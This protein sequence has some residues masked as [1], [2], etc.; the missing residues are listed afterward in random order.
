MTEQAALRRTELDASWSV[1]SIVLSE[2]APLSLRDKDIPA[3]VPGTVH[4]DLLSAG[5]IADPYVSQNEADLQWIGRSSW[6]YQT[7]F[8]WV[9]DAG[10]RT[11]LV[12]H[13][14][15]T[16]ASASL[17]GTGLLSASNMHRTYR[18]DVSD[19]I[20][21]GANELVVDFQA[22]VP[23]AEAQAAD[24]GS[25]PHTNHHPYNQIRKM[26]CNFGWDWGPDL[27]TVGLWRQVDIETWSTARIGSVRLQPDVDPDGNGRV[28]ADVSVEFAGGSPDALTLNGEI[29]GRAFTETMPKGATTT[30]FTV[31][32]GPVELWWPHTMGKQPL[33]GCTIDLRVDDQPLDRVERTIGFRQIH[34]EQQA[35]AEGSS[36]QLFVNR[37]PMWVR[38]A[39]WIPN[40]AFPSRVSA[41]DYRTRIDQARD[42]QIDLLRVWGGGIYESDDFYDACDELGVLVWQDFLFTCAAYPERDDFAAEVAAEA[43]DNIVRLAPHPSLALWNGNNENLWGFED[44]GWKEPLDGRPWGNG[45]YRELLPDLVAELDPGRP[46]IP[47]SPYSPGDNHPNDPSRGIIHIWD[48]WNTHDYADYRRYQARFVS[49]FGYQAPATYSTLREALSGSEMSKHAPALLSHQK[50]KDGMDKLR[51][52]LDAH[53]RDP[54]DF[55]DWHFLAQLNQARAISLGVEWFRSLKQ[56]SGS[57]VWQLND[58]WPVVSWSAIDGS[59]RKKPLWYA[60]RRAY[61]DRL[62]TVQPANKTLAVV[63]HNLSPDVWEET[64]Q[65]CRV[66]TDR[67][68]KAELTL[69]ASCEPGDVVQIDLPQDVATSERPADEFLI[70]D[71]R[72]QRSVWAYARDHSINYPEGSYDAV[73][74]GDDNCQEVT[75][76]AKTLLRDICLFPD[77]VHPDAEVDKM[78]V[79]LLPGESATF[80]VSGVDSA[81]AERLLDPQ[82]LR[83]VNQQGLL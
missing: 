47:G 22:P 37:Q 79:T 3:T 2:D 35:D 16:V 53:L 50:A 71:G 26:A 12:F 65:V 82:V 1:R 18:V 39:N 49:E 8:D 68:V 73:V 54:D 38:G 72:E 42:A 24:H 78:L 67:D 69:T 76:R 60:L 34:I 63:M 45:Y 32:V 59:G 40:D 23:Y 29:A 57:V 58:C 80:R 13:G 5:L 27:A 51:R 55:D 11:E 17:N 83:F 4:T 21:S 75:I 33:Y 31:D 56:M 36:W 61:A 77:R 66:S 81:N 19:I 10:E 74:D 41:D 44:W 7:Q 43:R 46:Y 62:L 25:L 52:G 30:S 20:S 70:V 64:L 28:T 6:R 48:V 9:A 14:L 15:D